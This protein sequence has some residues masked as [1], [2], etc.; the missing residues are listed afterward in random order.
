MEHS[1]YSMNVSD[2][3]EDEID[4]AVSDAL[5]GIV[6]AMDMRREKK[7]FRQEVTDALFDLLKRRDLTIFDVLIER[8][9]KVCEIL[10]EPMK[11]I[12]E[13]KMLEGSIDTEAVK[14]YN[15]CSKDTDGNF[16]LLY[17]NEFTKNIQMTLYTK[18]QRLKM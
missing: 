17:T 12:P 5:Q 4:K 14:V 9:E 10:G 18:R 1:K 11:D 8:E 2:M 16:E 3:N 13:G 7:L 6:T 15:L